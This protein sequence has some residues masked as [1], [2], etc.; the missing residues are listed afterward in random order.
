MI[1]RVSRV[2]CVYC[3][4]CICVRVVVGS[5]IKNNNGRHMALTAKCVLACMAREK[6][7][8]KQLRKSLE[9][10]SVFWL[11]VVILNWQTGQNSQVLISAGTV[12]E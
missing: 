6:T 10:I 5:V 8:F 9:N 4:L 3:I 7:V 2:V 11:R 12:I 1:V